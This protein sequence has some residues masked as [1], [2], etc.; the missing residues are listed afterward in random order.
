MTNTFPK[1][2][3]ALL[4]YTPNAWAYDNVHQ[5]IA[6]FGAFCTCRQCGKTETMAMEIH[7]G[8]TRPVDPIFG[9][10]LVGVLSY[11]YDHAEMSVMKW[12][13]R[14]KQADITYK[15]N[16]NKHT[17]LLDANGAVLRWLS[18][19]D[20]YSPA[21]YAWSKFLIDEAQ[22]VPDE[23]WNKLR[24]GLDVRLAN[25]RAFGTPDVIPEQTWFEGLFL[26]GQ[27]ENET[28]YA[29]FTLP[30]YL[31]RWMLPETVI[32]ARETMTAD[33][34]K[35]LYL[36]QWITPSNRVFNSDAVDACFTA[37]YESKPQEGHT[38]IMGLDIG[39]M[40]DYT[41]AYI[42]DVETTKIVA[43]LRFT[44]KF[45]PDAERE[46]LALHKHWNV[47]AVL[48]EANGPGKPLADYM[49]ASGVAVN[50]VHIASKKKG[51][52]I[53]T[54]ARDIEHTRIGL[55]PDPQLKRE[56][57]AYSRKVSERGIIVYTA[58]TNFFDDCVMAAAYTAYLMRFP[59]TART[60]SYAT[61]G[62]T[63]KVLATAGRRIA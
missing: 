21:G 56:L 50:D 19:D 46:L 48:M 60:S 43:G 35:M 51:E 13:D 5:C 62:S 9:P 7:E 17:I 52:V 41:V 12:V 20:P 39:Q 61:F 4:G 49:R 22:K 44:G 32:E 33:E 24:P 38:Y 54:L 53:Q 28:N 36:G 16:Q 11:D 40:H 6:R 25:L 18:A 27:D 26:R 31:N 37:E 1:K 59:G 58:P 15:L 57:K 34:F 3:W 55:P 42:G 23:V 63:N 10:P 30:C 2:G 29:S 8:M 45:Y 47:N 14:L